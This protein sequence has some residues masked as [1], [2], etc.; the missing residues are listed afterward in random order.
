MSTGQS[1]V[2]YRIIKDFPAY[3]VGSDGSTWSRFVR[4]KGFGKKHQIGSKWKRLKAKPGSHGYPVVCLSPGRQWFC[5]HVLVLNAFR[6]PC[7]EGMESRHFPD[8]SRTNCNL[9]NLSW[10]PPKIN[11]RDRWIHGTDNRGENHYAAKLTAKDVKSIRSDCESGIATRA[12]LARHFGIGPSA[13]SRIVSRKAW[14][15]IP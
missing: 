11:Q 5:V 15:S 14:G 3:R 10:A 4:K 6:G 9:A 2:E 7:P 1:I 13:I 12:E 8:R